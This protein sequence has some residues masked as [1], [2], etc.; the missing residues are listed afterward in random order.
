LFVH[1]QAVAECAGPLVLLPPEYA[2]AGPEPRGP[3]PVHRRH[4]GRVR[5]ARGARASRLGLGHQLTL[6]VQGTRTTY[7][8][9]SLA[10]PKKRHHFVN[11][12]VAIVFRGSGSA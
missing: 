10:E 1:Y 5:H 4:R 6:R 12:V 7:S 9:L 2:G 11:V 8:T 3:G